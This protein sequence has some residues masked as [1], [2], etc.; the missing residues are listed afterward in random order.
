MLREQ[1]KCQEY[2]Y[3][4]KQGFSYIVN[5]RCISILVSHV[6]GVKYDF[7]IIGIPICEIQKCEPGNHTDLW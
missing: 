2:V 5:C 7:N 1:L 6:R 3:Q 4:F